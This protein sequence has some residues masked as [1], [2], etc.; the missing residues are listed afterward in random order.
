MTLYV[1]TKNDPREVLTPVQQAIHAAAP[2]VL[3][4]SAR[5]GRELVNGA[6]FQDKM[7]VTLLSVFG[8]LALSL[9]S[10]GLYG[11]MAYSVNQRRREIGLR[12]ALGATETNVLGL[13]LRQGM[14]LVGAGVVL[15]FAAALAV[16]RLLRGMLFGLNASDPFSVLGAAAMLLIVAL[17]A[18]YLP[19]RW[20]S[21]VDPSVAL[22]ES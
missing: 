3:M 20:A 14:L 12:M 7:G 11:I 5:T 2:H 21:N 10:I 15:G 22:R 19:A 17:L 16:G 4:G 1:R 9:A 18:C 8:L 6:L 13:I